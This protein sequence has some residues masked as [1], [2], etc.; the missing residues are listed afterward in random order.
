RQSPADARANAAVYERALAAID[1]VTASPGAAGTLPAM[2]TELSRAR[3]VKRGELLE[4]LEEQLKVPPR[5]RSLLR[6]LYHRLESGVVPGPGLSRR[7]LAALGQTLRLP[8]RE[9]EAA[10]EPLGPPRALEAAQAFGR[11]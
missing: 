2:L 7:L 8:P 6:R 11:G 3:A 10:S 5:A 9:L 4:Q 1:R